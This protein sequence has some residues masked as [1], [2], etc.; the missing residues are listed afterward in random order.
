MV[1]KGKHMDSKGEIIVYKAPD[2]KTVVDVNL[3][4]N[5]VW[6]SLN[7]MAKL[8]G[9]DKSVVLKHLR[10]IFKTKEFLDEF[11]NAHQRKDVLNQ[12]PI[13]VITNYDVSIYGA[14]FAAMHNI[15]D[16]RETI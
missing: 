2:G 1:T 14:C 4:E 16:R 12:T 7:Q 13:Y 8:F 6:L 5:T 15:L 3:K 10:K 9:R 11:E